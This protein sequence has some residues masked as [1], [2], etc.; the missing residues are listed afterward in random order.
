[1]FVIVAVI[2]VAVILNR[3]EDDDKT[4]A[5]VNKILKARSFLVPRAAAVAVMSPEQSR[6]GRAA[7][8]PQSALPPPV[9]ARVAHVGPYAHSTHPATGPAQSDRAQEKEAHWG[10]PPG[11]RAAASMGVDQE[12][13]QQTSVVRGGT[14][15]SAAERRPLLPKNRAAINTDL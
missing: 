10:P 14:A 4:K 13:G 2:C 11:S 5:S 6:E 9:R 12:G 1:M 15:T 3:D 7:R 8:C